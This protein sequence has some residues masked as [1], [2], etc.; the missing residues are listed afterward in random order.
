MHRSVNR[1]T[2]SGIAEPLTAGIASGVVGFASTFAVVLAG[3]SA[4]GASPAQAAS[5]LAAVTVL[6]GLATVLLSWRYR[7]PITVVWSTPGAALLISVGAVAGGWP[8]AVG[9][10]AVTGVLLALTGLWP[11]L[12]S[13][14]QRIPA[15]LAQAM[16]A[17]ILLPL[18]LAPFRA[19]VVEPWLVAPV[20]IAWLVTMRL[21]ARWAVL[22]AVAAGLIAVGAHRALTGAAFD[23]AAF[24]PHFEW[25]MPVV[26]LQA[27]TGVALPLY[28]VT[29][30]SQNIPGAAVLQ[31]F[32]YTVPW[33]PALVTTGLGTVVG[34]FFGAFALNLAAI[35]AAL[36]AG[37]D[38]GADKQRRWIAG[39]TAGCLYIVL[40]LASAGLVAVTVA[41]PPEIMQAVA[42][43]ALFGALASAC[44][45]ALSDPRGRIAAIVTM[46]VAASGVV[47]AGLGAAFWALAIGLITWV[48][49]AAGKASTTR[50]VSKESA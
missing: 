7:M 15:S 36:A 22:A 6:M 4:V 32:G 43:V 5:G 3:L 14:V 20:L 48:V 42:G 29:M 26:A 10:F 24:V 27:L 30:A 12:A 44:V 16:L 39:F 8:A 18:C 9:A 28:I 2:G 41:A 21:R 11:Q 49:T 45:E 23:A 13:L 31:S 38:A 35:T 47:V 34:A 17:G 46:L 1:T 19:L 50:P 25:T 33:K 37:A 40:G